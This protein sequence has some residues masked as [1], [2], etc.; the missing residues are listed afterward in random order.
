MQKDKENQIRE[1]MRRFFGLKQ[2]R[3]PFETNYWQAISE[4]LL[5]RRGW[6]ESLEDPQRPGRKRQDKIINN[7]P[8]RALRIL[9]AGMQGGLTSPARQWFR[10]NLADSSVHGSGAVREYLSE[11]ER[12]MYMIFAS[13]NFYSSIHMAYT[14]LAGFGTCCLLEDEDPDKTVRFLTLT[15]GEYYLAEDRRGLVNTVYR[16]TWMSAAQMEE[17]FGRNVVSDQVKSALEHDPDRK[18]EVLHLVE[19]RSLRNQRSSGNMDMPFKSVYLELG[20]GG[21]LLRESGYNEF[22]YLVSRW[23]VFGGEVYGR[24]PGNDVLPDVKMLQE[25]EKTHLKAL[26]KMAD[27]PV[28]KPASLGH[29]VNALPGGVTPYDASNPQALAPLYEVTPNTAE[30]DA[31]I[32]RVEMAIEKALFNDVFLFNTYTSSMTATEVEE[33]REE[34][35]LMLGPVIERQTHELLDPLIDRTFNLMNRKGMLPAPPREIQGMDLKVEFV[36]HLAQAQKV[37]ATKSIRTVSAYA[38]ELSRYSNEALD[39]FNVEEALR[40]FSEAAGAPGNLIRGEREV[41]KLRSG[42]AEAVQRQ[43]VEKSQDRI[44]DNLPKTAQA[45]KDLS[46]INQKGEDALKNLVKLLESTASPQA[47]GALEGVQRQ[48]N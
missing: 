30:L 29:P 18:F 37:V 39:L 35:L 5:P 32:Q 42:K 4:Y 2:T 13:S 26:H 43:L 19:P 22:P 1:Y 10:L 31:K 44:M 7:Q 28:K 3:Q 40:Q 36:S 46:Q 33:R 48:V 45:A 16:T 21:H 25:M 41:K 23:S 11:V 47:G 38:A 27:P 6:F 24:G 15:A 9:S 20:G 12:R 34:K 8:T 14:E 17:E